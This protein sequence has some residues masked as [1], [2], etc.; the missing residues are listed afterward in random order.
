MGVNVIAPGLATTVQ[1]LGRP[2]YYHLGIPEGGGMDRFA[3][4]IA[5]LLVGND[6]NAALLEATF[7]GPE[8]EFTED[9]SVAVTGGELPP[10]VNGE[11]RPTWE[12]FPVKAGDRLSF[13]FLKG[14]AR[15]Y[16][17]ISGG[18]DVPVVLG[19]RTTYVLGALGGLEGRAIKAG[20]VLPVGQG[21]NT[22]GRSLPAHLRRAPANPAELR[23]LPGIYWHRITDA[24]GK[25]FF[26]DTWKVAPE[27]DRIGYRFRGGAPLEFVEREQPFGAGSDPSNIVDACY[28]YG[29]VQVPSGTE[30]IVLHRDAVS[31]GGYMMLGVVISADMDLI[32]QLQPHTPA[33]FQPVTMD[34]A[35][36]ARADARTALQR[37]RDHVAG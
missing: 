22:T 33:R 4:V 25:R 9:A 26:E 7:M 16:I 21:A 15:A 27:A 12:S 5:N 19:S 17:A 35:L 37:A 34:E 18:I 20:D 11:E 2:G 8:L 36:A 31:G 23:M 14:G 28:P 1:D 13:G 29:S 6:A 24:A 30:P 10:K 3:T 32:A